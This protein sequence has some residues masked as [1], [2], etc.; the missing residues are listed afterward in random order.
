MTIKVKI[1]ISLEQGSVSAVYTNRED[2]EIECA[3]VDYDLTPCQDHHIV[4]QDDCGSDYMVVPVGV[5]LAAPHVVSVHDT[6]SR[7]ETYLDLIH[8]RD[9]TEEGE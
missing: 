6:L 7:G 1:V 5:Q 3:V 4:G 8:R 9:Y 2:V